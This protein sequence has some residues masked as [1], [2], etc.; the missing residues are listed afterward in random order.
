MRARGEPVLQDGTVAGMRGVLQDIDEAKRSEQRLRQS[1][2]RFSRIFQ[3]MPYPMGMTRQSDGCYVEVNPAW[4]QMLGYTR[5]Q[6]VGVSPIQLGIFQAQDRIRLI[7]EARK[8]GQLDAYEV[9]IIT[10]SG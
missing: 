1:E 5:A 4:E 2:D 10:R 3:L 6:A 8:T 9:K 7:D